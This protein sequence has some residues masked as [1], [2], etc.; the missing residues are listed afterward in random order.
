VAKGLGYDEIVE[1]LMRHAS[2]TQRLLAACAA[3]D[4]AVAE[5]I[6]ASHPNVI[7]GLTRDQMQLIVDRAHANDTAA[8]AL[9]LRLG[10]DPLARGVD[11]WEAIRWA[12]FHGNAEMVELLLPHNPP[13]GI[14]D[15]TYGGTPLGQCLYGSL[16]GWE[17]DTGDFATTVRLL[18]DAGE[19]PELT[20]VPIGRDDVDAVLREHFARL[21]RT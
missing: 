13:I 9:M 4:R 1:L 8:V 20:V 3:A 16:H 21:R 17:C 12:A 11:D 2:P 5:A 18:L 10:F 19:R 14:P 6:V 7:A 15:P